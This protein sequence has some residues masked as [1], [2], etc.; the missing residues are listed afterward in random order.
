MSNGDRHHQ[1]RRRDWARHHIDDA[2][3]RNRGLPPRYG[4]PDWHNLAPTDPQRWAA[5]IIAA[6][7]WARSEDDLEDTLRLQLEALHA[8][9]DAWWEEGHQTA[10]GIAQAAAR[11]FGKPRP[12]QELPA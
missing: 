11:N 5:V 7:A 3:A 8:A 12:G 6:E 1:E 9:E 4:S 2:H 10:V